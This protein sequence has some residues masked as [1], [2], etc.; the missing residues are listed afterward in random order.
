MDIFETIH[1]ARAG[2]YRLVTSCFE[3]SDHFGCDVL[4]FS[5][6]FDPLLAELEMRPES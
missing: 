1:S 3:V 5:Q 2:N 4:L 6:L